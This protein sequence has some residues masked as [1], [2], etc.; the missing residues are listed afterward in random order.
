MAISEREVLE[1]LKAVED[2]DL[3]RDIVSEWMPPADITE[4]QRLARE[5][6]EA[7]GE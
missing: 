5:W 2:P 7:R 3:H 6:L 4:A 1:A